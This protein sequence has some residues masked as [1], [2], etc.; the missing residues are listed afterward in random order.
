[1]TETL[2]GMLL[3]PQ[4]QSKT[5][6]PQKELQQSANWPKYENHSGRIN[7]GFPF[8]E[9][10]PKGGPFGNVNKLYELILV[11]GKRVQAQVDYSTQYRA[12]GL[13][14]LT[15][16]RQTIGQGVVAAWREVEQVK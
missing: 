4:P 3:A 6:P 9:Y 10:F 1:M 11:G 12:E 13:Q 8:N 5:Q 16:E 15:Q 7:D 2:D 14:W